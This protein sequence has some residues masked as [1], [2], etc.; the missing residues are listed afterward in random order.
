MRSHAAKS[1]SPEE[2]DAADGMIYD[3]W[4]DSAVGTPESWDCWLDL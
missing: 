4:C 2:R 1:R 3:G